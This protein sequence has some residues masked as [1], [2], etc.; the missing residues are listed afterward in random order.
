MKFVF[1][2]LI[3]GIVTLPLPFVA[4]GIIYFGLGLLTETN[5]ASVAQYQNN[6]PPIALAYVLVWLFLPQI[7]K[8]L[9]GEPNN[10]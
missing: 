6:L 10:E 4:Y 5:T 3:I 1:R 8:Y 7:Q 9:I 2:R